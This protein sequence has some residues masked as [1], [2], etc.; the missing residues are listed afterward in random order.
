MTRAKRLPRFWTEIR[1]GARS[2]AVQFLRVCPSGASGRSPGPGPVSARADPKGDVR[3][4]HDPSHRQGRPRLYYLFSTRARHQRQVLRGP[5]AWRCAAT[6]S[7]TFRGWAVQD[8]PGLRGLW[9]PDVSYFNG[10]YH[11]YYSASTF[12]SNRSSIGLVT[13]VTLDPKRASPDFRS[14]RQGKGYRVGA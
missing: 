8:V 7:R 12:G 9:A 5:R 4:V 1:S 10:K 13:N 6:S 3:K 14:A 2:L 11:L